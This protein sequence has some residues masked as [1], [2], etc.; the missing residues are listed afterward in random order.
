MT[1]IRAPRSRILPPLF[2]VLLLLAPI[3]ASA[4]HFG[5]NKIQYENFD[6]RILNTPHFEIFFY[7]GEEQLAARA[8]LIVEDAYLRLSE[9]FGTQL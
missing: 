1:C 2:A 8:A 3:G 5:R 9:T 6:W 7:E 4:Q